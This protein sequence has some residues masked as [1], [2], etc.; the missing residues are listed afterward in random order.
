[1]THH[2]G[3]AGPEF[4]QDLPLLRLFIEDVE[5]GTTLQ[6]AQPTQVGERRE[7]E[8]LGLGHGEAPDEEV[9][10][11]RVVHV[12]GGGSRVAGD[13]VNAAA[14]R[15]CRHREAS[16]R[17]CVRGALGQAARATRPLGPPAPAHAAPAVPALPVRGVVHG[18]R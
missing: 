11:A 18:K 4:E 12:Y 16:R 6:G 3:Q 8:V 1:M 5:P 7:V 15:G 17:R 2:S 14:C 13:R 10:E 9:K